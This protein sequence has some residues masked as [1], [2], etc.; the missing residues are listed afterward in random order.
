MIQESP[1]QSSYLVRHHQ[2]QSSHRFIQ[3]SIRLIYLLK[4]QDIT[5]PKYIQFF[6]ILCMS[7]CLSSMNRD[8]QSTIITTYDKYY[9]SKNDLT[10][11]THTKTQFYRV[12]I[13]VILIILTNHNLLSLFKSLHLMLIN[14]CASSQVPSHIQPK[15]NNNNKIYII[16]PKVSPKT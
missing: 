12:H 14:S 2:F 15:T 4:T 9:A 5:E 1:F 11:H 16:T 8:K 10:V 13:V 7:A 6:N 3:R